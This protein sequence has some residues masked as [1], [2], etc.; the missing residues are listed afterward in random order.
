METEVSALKT[1]VITS[2]PSMPNRHLHPHLR[3][4]RGGSRGNGS[5]SESGPPSP[6]REGHSSLGSL[7]G[8][9]E[10]EETCVDPVLRAEYVTWKRSPSMEPSCQFLSRIYRED[11]TPCLDFPVVELADRVRRAVQ[12]FFEIKSQKFSLHPCRTTLYALCPSKPTQ[13][14][15][16]KDKTSQREVPGFILW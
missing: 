3:K 5:E 11:V 14:G 15:A 12:G 4:G 6:A 2:T 16:H 10:K 8:E 1:L 7:Q 9:E 13:N